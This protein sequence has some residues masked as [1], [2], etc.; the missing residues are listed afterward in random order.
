MVN[1]EGIY[2]FLSGLNKDLDEVRGRRLGCKPLPSIDEIFAEVR[3]EET[4]KRVMLG[5]VKATTENSAFSVRGPENSHGESQ[6]QRKG[7]NLWCDHCQRSNHSRDKCWK[8]YG[9]PD[10]LKDTRN[11]RRDSKGF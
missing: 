2:D 6:N 4:C 11:N 5:T 10:N 1:N 7:G 8:L 9:K 3:R